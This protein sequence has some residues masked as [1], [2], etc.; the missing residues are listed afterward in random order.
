MLA[1]YRG[2]G[3]LRVLQPYRPVAAE[4]RRRP[5]DRGHVSAPRHRRA[6]H[7]R[8]RR[9]SWT[10]PRPA[11]CCRWPASST[12]PGSSPRTTPASRARPS[13]AQPMNMQAVSVCFAVD[14]VDGDHTI[15]RPA[16]YGF[17]RDYQPPFWG[18]RMLSFRSPNPRTLRD[19]ASAA[20]PPIRT[21]TRCRSAPTSGSTRA[22]ATC[23]RSGGSPRGAS[24]RPAPTPATSAWS[25]GR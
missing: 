18:D 1:P 8:P 16:R 14:H 12:S 22:T 5:G 20:S 25:T 23:G 3:R 6:D 19:R 7:G 9:T 21:T 4:H 11:S 17:W 13:T 10:R 24:S 15:D 2:S